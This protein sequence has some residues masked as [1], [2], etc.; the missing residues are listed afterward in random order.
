MH[1]NRLVKISRNNEVTQ[2]ITT[3]ESILS[4]KLWRNAQKHLKKN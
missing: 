2:L 3:V 4:I 1:E